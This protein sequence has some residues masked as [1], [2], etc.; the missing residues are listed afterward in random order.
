MDGGVGAV[1]RLRL[2]PEETVTAGAL[3]LGLWGEVG[4]ADARAGRAMVRVQ[5]LLGPEAALTGVLVGGRDPGERVR[6]VPWGDERDVGPSPPGPRPPEPPPPGPRPPEPPSPG[7]ASAEPAVPEPVAP[8]PANPLR[9]PA[10]WPDD[11]LQATGRV[12]VVQHPEPVGPT[13]R[14]RPARGVGRGRAVVPD[15]APTWPGQVPAPS[16]ATVPVDPLPAVVVDAA[17]GP[18]GLAESDLLTAPPHRVAVDGGPAREVRGWA[19]PWPLRQRWWVP[20]AV[21]G[22]R[23]QVVLDDDSALLLLAREA[24]WWV[25]GVYD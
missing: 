23:L 25:V 19:G 12:S 22:T 2:V 14:R 6:L 13:R 11:V 21:D 3:Q 8:A 9:A 1:S 24:R 17:G 4:E 7:R 10:G 20:D 16:P 18:V 15:P 5:A